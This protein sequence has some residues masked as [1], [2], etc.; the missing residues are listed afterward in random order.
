MG[1]EGGLE[2][3]QKRPSCQ[4]RAVAVRGK[5]VDPDLAWGCKNLGDSDDRSIRWALSDHPA[6]VKPVEDLVDL[7]E[8]EPNP[9][10]VGGCKSRMIGD[11]PE[12]AKCQSVLG[13]AHGARE[14]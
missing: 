1:L 11:A 4:R 10:E 14:R 6:D 13:R 5:L 9:S 12:G 3:G 2:G 7:R 8:P